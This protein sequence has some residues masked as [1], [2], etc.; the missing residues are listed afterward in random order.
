M[1]NPT[2]ITAERAARLR[3][4]FP[5][6]VPALWCPAVTHYTAEGAIDAERIA[7]HWR[8]LAPA[9]RGLLI[10]GSTGDGWELTEPELEQLRE[11][12]FAEAARLGLHLLVGALRRD[13]ESAVSTI[14]A[15]VDRVQARTGQAERAAALHEAGVCGF[16]V[17]APAGRDLTQSQIRA[18]LVAILELGFPTAIYQLPQVTENEISP[19]VLAELA[20]GFSNFIL[21][22]DTSGKDRVVLSERSLGGVFTVRGAEGDYARWLNAAGG[23]YDGFLLS[24]ANC[25]ARELQ[26]IMADLRAGRRA[27]AEALSV[28]LTAVIAE[29]FQLVGGLP[30]GNAFANA[31]KA[32]DHFFAHGPAAMELPFPRLHAGACLPRKVMEQTRAALSR[33]G[34][35]PTQGYLR[36]GQG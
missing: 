19:E 18:G 17:C 30:C 7:A 8:H 20:A 34:F 4:L 5:S 21:F 2:P 13:A 12:A 9:V 31:N 11:I 14:R 6:G 24:A 10:P 23:P 3:E 36:S 16:T 26:Q 28:R 29:V 22:M 15:V 35:L 1:T 27:D 25:F 32:I 33:H